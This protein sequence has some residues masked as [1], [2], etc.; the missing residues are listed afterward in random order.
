MPDMID[1]QT[2]QARVAQLEAEN[3]R[4]RKALEEARIQLA[5]VDGRYP[6]WATPS[7]IARINA[8]LDATQ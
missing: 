5:Y 1:L 6:T 2:A 7:I 4:L 8:V 3:A